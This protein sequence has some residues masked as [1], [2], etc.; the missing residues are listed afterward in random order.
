MRAIANEIRAGFFYVKAS[1]LISPYPG[2]SAQALAKIFATAKKQAPCILFFDEI[3]AIAGRRET[4]LSESG[5][6]LI[7]TMLSEM[8]GFQKISNIVIV[9]ATNVPHFLDPSIM[10]P[11]RF[12]KILY[13]PLPD[14]SGRAKIFKYYLSR[15]PADKA[16]DCEKLAS[17]TARYSGADIK[18]ICEEVG[19]QVGD[20]ALSKQ[21]MLVIRMSD[22][23]SVIKATKPSTS[24][25]QI[26]E[27]NTF[28]LDYERR[29]HGEIQV[30]NEAKTAIDD[31]I[32]LDEPKKALHDAV[33]VPI[34]HPD[35]VKKYDVGSIRGILLFGPPGTGKT[36]LMTAVANEL[37][38]VRVLT[39]C[40]F[41]VAKYGADKAISAIKEIFDRAKEHAPAIVFI[42]EIDALVPSRDSASESGMQIT[43]E[44]LQEFDKIKDSGVVVVA[45]T[46]RPDVL[47]PALLRAGRLDKLIFVA[48]PDKDSRAKIFD[49]NLAKVPLSDDI[50]LDALAGITEGYTGADIANICRQAKI[51]ALETSVAKG[52]EAKVEMTEIDKAA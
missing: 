25:S 28:K 31:V 8:D 47:D 51:D 37:G 22:V 15:L 42:D 46:N 18:N 16:I 48:P 14:Q 4:Q 19:R 17:L 29:T 13:M 6:E 20:A 43:G 9:G 2:E 44:F 30:E 3:D 10:R 40:G 41:D 33:E 38:D 7:T 24:L 39:L 34:L 27:Y 36:M 1:S 50:D 21:E 12:D 52:I 32:G 35:L 45:A 5:R 26:E 49:E 11:G 23:L